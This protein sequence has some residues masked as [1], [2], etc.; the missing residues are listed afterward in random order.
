MDVALD[1]EKRELSRCKLL[2]LECMSNEV[3][4]Y[5]TGNYIQPLMIEH[6][7]SYYEK[8]PCIYMYDWVTSLY[9]RN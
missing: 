3:L 6:D 8:N 5:G 9:S 7:G 2:P 1:S 4:L